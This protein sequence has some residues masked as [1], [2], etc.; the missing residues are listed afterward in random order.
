MINL[1]QYI[2]DLQS[3]PFNEQTEHSKRLVLEILLKQAASHCVEN[4][5][6]VSNFSEIIVLHE[7]KRIENYG[8]PDFKIYSA[9]QIIGY[10]ENKKITENL[11]KILKTEQ[12]N[13]YRELSNNILLTNYIEFIWIK[14][15]LMQRETLCYLSDLENNKFKIEKTKEEKVIQLLQNFF[16]QAPKGV[17][18][19][20]ELAVALAV[21]CRNLKNYL[22]DELNQQDKASKK[23]TLYDIYEIFKTHVF[24]ELTISEFCD[25][26]AQMLV[27]GLFLAK[28]NADTQIVSLNN[29]EDFIPST[30]QLIHELVKY[31]KELKNEEYNETKWIIEEILFI[32]NNLDLKI[33]KEELS[34]KNSKLSTSNSQLLTFDSQ[35]DSDP[36]IYFYETFLSAYDSK[37]RKTKGVYYTPNQVVNFIVKSINNILQNTFKIT[38][39]LADRNSVTVLDFATG[40][41]TFMLEIFKQ[42]LNPAGF[43]NLNP[44]GFENPQDFGEAKNNL[45]IKEH[46]LKN[47]YGFEYLIAP[48][49][50]A[51]LKLSQ[52]LKENGYEFQKNE[53]LQIFLTNTLEPIENQ[54]KIPLFPALTEET[55]KAQEIKNKSIL[56]ITGNPPYSGHSTNNGKWILDLIKSYFTLN[57]KPLKERNSKWLQDDYVKFIR[58]AENKMQ[59]VEQGIVAIITNHSFLDNP[60]FAGMRQSLIKTFDH[61]YFIDLHGNSLKKEKTPDGKKDENVFDIQQGVCISIMVK[62]KGLEKQIFHSDFF[63]LRSR[64]FDLCLNQNLQNIDF[65]ILN[66]NSPFYL[67]IPQNQNLRA[68]YEKF[69]SLKDI[70]E[71][72]GVGITT[73]HDDLL[74]SYNQAEMLERFEKLKKTNPHDLKEIFNLTDNFLEKRKVFFSKIEEKKL[75]TKEINY[76]P[77]DKRFIWNENDLIERTRENVMKH[78]DKQNIGLVYTRFAYKKKF[79]IFLFF[80]FG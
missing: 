53:R 50:I 65:K 31:L 47:I 54:S 51:H 16:S 2:S 71:V 7:P 55:K 60:T 10:V 52:F 49:T 11:D 39:G 44:A 20:K 33:I 15:D 3:V 61:L 26:F 42:I 18:N 41:G 57:G 30:F 25:A 34:Y 13:K 38:N 21:R 58:F 69:W 5:G 79:R 12:I 62:N 19:T 48:Y 8:A 66:P 32:L 4:Q 67:F 17:A 43:E 22:T 1:Q 70:F 6:V 46:L 14:A 72:G 23:G 56:V 28:L 27:Y 45:I 59:N 80:C 63:G 40:T 29:I 68:V 37:L 77:L 36:Y 9:A 74:I 76:R 73:A 35:L 75:I 64:K 78:F 24:N